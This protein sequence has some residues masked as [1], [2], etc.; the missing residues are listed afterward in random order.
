MTRLPARLLLVSDRIL[1][2]RPLDEQIGRAVDAG[3]RWV[4]LRDKDLEKSE[5]RE[6]AR[7]LESRLAQRA[8]LTIGA[9]LDL[10]EELGADAVHLP[11]SANVEMAR[12]R[13]GAQA[14]IGL[15]A[16]TLEDV[17]MAHRL[18]ADYVTLSPVFL[19]ASKPDYGPAHGLGALSAARDMGIPVLALGGITPLN[20]AQCVAHGAYGI[21]VMGGIMAR[22]DTAAAIRDYSL[23]LPDGERCA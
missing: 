12:R 5:R 16:H 7:K 17:K 6:F 4:W 13:L 22:H 3:A 1:S 19:S 15:S 21:A 14:L 2:V 8:R 10:A 9:D 18:R 11:M 23:Q 20:A